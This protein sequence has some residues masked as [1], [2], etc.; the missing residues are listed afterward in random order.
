MKTF[1]SITLL[2]LLFACSNSKQPKEQMI[3]NKSNDSTQILI[4]SLIATLDDNYD[5]LH[6]D[7][8]PSVYKL[9]ELG[10]PAIVAV[11]PLLNNAKDETRLHAQRV[12]EGVVMRM[13]GFIPGQG[14]S[15]NPN[16]ED[17]ARSTLESIGYDYSDST[18]QRQIAIENW[19]KWIGES[20][21]N[22]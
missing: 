8:T 15:N 13:Y 17:T 11:L 2:T 5:M 16:G 1:F 20:K 12:T 22:K 18:E 19:I 4:D 10:I 6:S 3:V 7:Y 14:F 21:K 9:S